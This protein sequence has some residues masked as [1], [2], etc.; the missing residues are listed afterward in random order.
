METKIKPASPVLIRFYRV[1]NRVVS[2]LIVITVAGMIF[3]PVWV[4]G[5]K[6]S[7]YRAIESL[8]DMPVSSN[9]AG[10]QFMSLAG[11]DPDQY[12]KAAS[13][14]ESAV[15][16]E[17]Y[18][19]FWNDNKNLPQYHENAGRAFMQARRYTDAAK[20][21]E[22][23]LREFENT[24]PQSAFNIAFVNFMAAS[25]HS[26]LGDAET[27]MVRI[28]EAVRYF[29]ALSEDR[30]NM[31]A[32]KAFIW[33]SHC[34]YEAGEYENAAAYFE[35]GIPLYYDVIDWGYGDNGEVVF[36]AVF[37]DCAANVYDKLS[38]PEKAAEYR[39]ISEEIIYLRDYSESELSE[40]RT[41]MGWD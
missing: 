23:S 8:E 15:W 2:A 11:A 36:A 38:L 33:L 1:L 28:T 5:G 22:S 29:E 19:V 25:A 34:Y 4:L 12:S 41:H 39:K 7:I 30:R 6:S 31:D 16:F 27:E 37:F 24:S 13:E 26:A 35:M 32:G 14:F 40:L 3:M 21:Y 10:M 20:H 18:I 17:K 9:T